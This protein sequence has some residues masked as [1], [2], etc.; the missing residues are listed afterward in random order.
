MI[1][2]APSHT[3]NLTTRSVRNE[4]I[5]NNL[6]QVASELEHGRS[7]AAPTTTQTTPNLTETSSPVGITT[8]SQRGTGMHLSL[9]FISE[10]LKQEGKWATTMHSNTHTNEIYNEIN[11]EINN[12]IND[13]INTGHSYGQG[14]D[15]LTPN[16]STF[17]NPALLRIYHHTHESVYIDERND[18]LNESMN[19][20]ET[21]RDVVCANSSVFNIQLNKSNEHVDDFGNIRCCEKD[22]DYDLRDGIVG[23]LGS[24]KMVEGGEE[25]GVDII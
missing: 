4:D 17:G 14:N 23:G 16:P 7:T 1:P 19:C 9:Q 3:P 22:E 10:R 11:N 6:N 2:I 20:G 24:E 21:G 5:L 18:N 12:G 25:M 13:G 15:T 8:H